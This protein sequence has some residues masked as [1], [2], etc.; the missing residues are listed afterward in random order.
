M[1]CVPTQK[2]GYLVQVN[3]VYGCYTDKEGNFLRSVDNIDT[4][5]EWAKNNWK[6]YGEVQLPQELE[7]QLLKCLQY[8]N[9]YKDSLVEE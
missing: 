2:G 5:I 1:L 6:V 8:V 3:G 9:E 7:Q 4:E